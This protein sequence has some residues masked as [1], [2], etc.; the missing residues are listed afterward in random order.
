MISLR[1]LYASCRSLALLARVVGDSSNPPKLCVISAAIQS[2]P[3]SASFRHSD[4]RGETYAVHVLLRSPR[5]K[6][7]C[8]DIGLSLRRRRLPR[9][10][11]CSE[12][13]LSILKVKYCQSGSLSSAMRRLDILCAFTN[14]V[15]VA[16]KHVAFVIQEDKLPHRA[17]V[18][19]AESAHQRY[20]S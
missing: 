14:D 4:H 16:S 11:V 13:W 9:Y 17:N 2:S 18:A 12:E 1:F 8:R 6:L 20:E 19:I 10:R 5:R 15:G 7:L 3:P